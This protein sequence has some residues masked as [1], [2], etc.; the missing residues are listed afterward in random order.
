[1][2]RIALLRGEVD[3]LTETQ[4]TEQQRRGLRFGYLGSTGSRL[5]HVTSDRIHDML[6]LPCC[7]QLL[8]QD[9]DVSRGG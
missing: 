2:R 5:I 3:R 4:R 7:G 9:V 1:M 8:P 6:C